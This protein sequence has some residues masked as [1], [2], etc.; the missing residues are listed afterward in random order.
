MTHGQSQS[1]EIAERAAELL[2]SGQDANWSRSANF[3]FKTLTRFN[4]NRRNAGDLVGRT[5]RRAAFYHQRRI[6]RKATRGAR[7]T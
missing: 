1:R 6:T 7:A 2:K 5:A 3:V 4:R